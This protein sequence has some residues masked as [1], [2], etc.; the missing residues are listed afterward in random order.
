MRAKTVQDTLNEYAYGAGFSMSS[1]GHFSGGMSGTTRGGFGGAW[2]MGGPNMMYTY[3]IKP[4]NHT[5]EQKPVIDIDPNVE[6]IYVGSKIRGTVVRSNATPEKKKIVGIVHKIVQTDNGSIKYYIVQDQATQE[7]VKID[8]LTAEL[9]IHEPVEYYFDNTDM[10][11]PP[12]RSS[13][14]GKNKKIF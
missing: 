13:R 5:L 11:R 6:Q 14:K 7:H 2:N 8:P 10:A 1:G 12:H 3:E 9:I 4:L